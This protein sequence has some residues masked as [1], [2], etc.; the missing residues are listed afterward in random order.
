MK[1]HS[2]SLQW[3][4]ERLLPTPFTGWSELSWQANESQW[5]KSG[6]CT[7]LAPSPGCYT[8][9][10]LNRCGGCWK[11]LWEFTQI[12]LTGWFTQR[13]HRDSACGHLHTKRQRTEWEL[14]LDWNNKFDQLSG[15]SLPLPSLA[16]RI[17]KSSL[18]QCLWPPDSLE[19]DS[20]DK[21]LVNLS[22]N[23][24]LTVTTQTPSEEKEREGCFLMA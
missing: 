21:V 13:S 1:L 19:D 4:Y 12:S 11:C 22:K 20:G 6:D 23:K 5:E 18:Y 10:K 7:T 14:F 8:E 9:K 16:K 15:P 24:H 3:S 17:P 2:S